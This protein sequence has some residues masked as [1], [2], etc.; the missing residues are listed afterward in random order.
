MVIYQNNAK[1]YI[2]VSAGHHSEKT[3]L[4]AKPR[5]MATFEN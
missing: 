3:Q 4:T 1:L 2:P 5:L